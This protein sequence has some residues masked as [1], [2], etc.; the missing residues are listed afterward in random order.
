[1]RTAPPLPGA[2]HTIGRLAKRGLTSLVALRA[3]AHG[4]DTV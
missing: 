1:V 2:R 3:V 4:R